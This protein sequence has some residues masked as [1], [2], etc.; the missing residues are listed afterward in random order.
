MRRGTYGFYCFNL[1]Q[2]K[3]L[4]F[5]HKI[6]LLKIEEKEAY[7]HI[8]TGK[9]EFLFV[10]IHTSKLVCR[11]ISWLIYNLI[12]DDASCERA[13]RLLD[14]INKVEDEEKEIV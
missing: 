5:F 1:T 13:R 12:M 9:A 14:A 4:E 11:F 3:V 10:R 7:R 8:L 2:F 6:R